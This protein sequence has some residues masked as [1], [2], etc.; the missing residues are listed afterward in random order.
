MSIIL[1]RSKEWYEA[2]LL[3]SQNG[4]RR[5]RGTADPVFIVKNLIRIAKSKNKSMFALA[6]DLR[7]AYDWINR[8][9]L[10]LCIAARNS[11][12]EHEGELDELFGLVRE[13][14]GRTYSF[15]SG[16]TTEQAF[17]TTSGLLQGAVE[18]PPLFSIFCDTIMRLFE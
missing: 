11:D 17:E 15:M 8:S 1:W 10:W 2:T 18:S 6:L 16:D 12:S 4:F 5:A 3:D 13:L 7:A 14:Y 9:W